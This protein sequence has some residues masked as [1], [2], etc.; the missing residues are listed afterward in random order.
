MED[1]EME[2][3]TFNTIGFLTAD[4]MD[5]ERM[6]YAWFH[7]KSMVYSQKLHYFC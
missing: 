5:T 1:K 3:N 6:N 7:V 4:N 2:T